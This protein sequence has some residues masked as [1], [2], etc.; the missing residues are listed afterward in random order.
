[1]LLEK[2]HGSARNNI[3]RFISAPDLAGNMV[4]G[5]HHHFG[6]TMEAK[7]HNYAGAC[8]LDDN[9]LYCTGYWTCILLTCGNKK[10]ALN[11]FGKAEAVTKM[12]N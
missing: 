11:F 3:L 6:N 1:M 10:T 7:G 9:H 5:S 8:I 12:Y 2:H 4:A